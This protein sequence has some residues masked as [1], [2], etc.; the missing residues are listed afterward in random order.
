VVSSI[1]SLIRF[2]STAICLI[3]IVSFGSFAIDQA[4]SAS[5]RQQ[6]QL[7]VPTTPS[8]SSTADTTGRAGTAGTVHRESAVHKT[9]EE[10][11]RRLT[12]PFSGVVSESSNEWAIRGA[13]LMLALLVYGFGLGYLARMLRVRV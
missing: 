13:K 6:E 7:A 9:L 3:V 10:A 2:A 1:V 11:S 5:T 12:S 4:K 8:P